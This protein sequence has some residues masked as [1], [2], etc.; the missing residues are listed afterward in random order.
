MFIHLLSTTTILEAL[1]I[2]SCL[3]FRG[4]SVPLAVVFRPLITASDCQG[5]QEFVSTGG[6]DKAFESLGHTFLYLAYSS[7]APTGQKPPGH[8]KDR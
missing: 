7:F 2:P 1:Y 3:T 8:E 6:A 4:S 5:P